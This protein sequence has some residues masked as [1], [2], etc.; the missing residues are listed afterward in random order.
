MFGFKRFTRKLQSKPADLWA[1]RLLVNTGLWQAVRICDTFDDDDLMHYDWMHSLRDE[2]NFAA[3]VSNSAR[4]L[5]SGRPADIKKRLL[6]GDDD[7]DDDDAFK[8]MQEAESGGENPEIGAEINAAKSAACIPFEKRLEYLRVA[9]R[10]TWSTSCQQSSLGQKAEN[11]G[12]YWKQSIA[13]GL[14]HKW[15]GLDSPASLKKELQERMDA[16]PDEL[17]ALNAPFAENIE[18]IASAFGLTPTQT[19]VLAFIL[20]ARAE[21]SLAS[22]LTLLDFSALPQ[23]A[24][25]EVIAAGL[26]LAVDEIQA[27]FLPESRLVRSELVRFSSEFDGEASFAQRFEILGSNRFRN[28]VLMPVTVDDIIDEAALKAPAPELTLKDFKAQPEVSGLLLPYLKGVLASHRKG[29]NVLLYG[30]PGTGKTQL[31]RVLAE[32]LGAELYEIS[33]E[34]SSVPHARSKGPRF[35]LDEKSDRKRPPRLQRWKVAS[36]ILAGAK[37]VI[38]AVDE[39]EDVF[40]SGISFFDMFH[41]ADSR[42]NKGEINTLLENNPVPT[43]WIANNI[44]RID[45]AMIRRF[46]IVLKLPIPT[47]SVRR[48]IISEAFE[49]ALSDESL[50]RLVQVPRLS[51]AVVRRA[52]T[53]AKIAGLSENAGK[54]PAALGP[55]A[56]KAVVNMIDATLSAQHF[57]G[58]PVRAKLLPAYYNPACVNA[59][60][61][62]KAIARGLSEARRGR[63]CLYGPPGTGKTAYAAWLARELDCPL[64]RKTYAELSSCF[65]GETEKKIAHAFKE[66]A[67]ENAVLLID[68]ADSFLRDRTLLHH[69]WET[70]Q[71][72]EMLAQMEAFEGIFIAST[73][74]METLDAASLRRFDLKARFDYLKTAQVLELA[75]ATLESLGLALDEAASGALARIEKLTPGD[76][77]AVRRQAAFNPIASAADFARRLLGEVRI[78]GGGA[79]K[80]GFS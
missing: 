37:N 6:D 27:C 44:D 65:V 74:L 70:T 3:V 8:A 17:K 66:A 4:F 47:E 2:L 23:N 49:G 36:V 21:T 26:D 43:F 56:E 19:K 78:K 39:A 41:G 5:Q 33:T 12:D 58:V 16:C 67:A 57:G 52:A 35:L 32:S 9:T 40:N 76:F 75:R 68:E 38:F 25:T 69:S 10:G 55:E 77:A 24:V 60:V 1:L 46:D 50:E 29:V 7:L 30:L 13:N 45:P 18:R 61:D 59:D 54:G 34:S 64:M 42:T 53:V 80:I 31:S 51:P 20:T 79:A 63:L 62:L 71:V 11:L 15:L 14:V 73:N 22:V 48:R 72:N 28:M